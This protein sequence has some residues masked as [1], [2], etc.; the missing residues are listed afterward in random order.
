MPDSKFMHMFKNSRSSGDSKS[1]SR[2]VKNLQCV[3]VALALGIEAQSAL[4]VAE[5]SETDQQVLLGH[6]GFAMVGPLYHRDAAAIEVVD[7]QPAHY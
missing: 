3:P 6:Q 1:S 2:T 4:G 5:E 7:D